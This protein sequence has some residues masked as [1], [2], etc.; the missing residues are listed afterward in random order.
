MVKNR[1]HWRAV[2]VDDA[3]VS[4]HST[5]HLNMDTKEAGAQVLFDT[6]RDKDLVRQDVPL[7]SP[8]AYT[9]SIS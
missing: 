2:D 6:I 7:L 4:Q 9:S 1:E 3:G 8:N 5:V